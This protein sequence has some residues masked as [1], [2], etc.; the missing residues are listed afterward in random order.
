MRS[1][2]AFAAELGIS[3]TCL[4]KWENMVSFPNTANLLKLSRVF[5]FNNLESFMAYL[6]ETEVTYPEEEQLVAE[7]L[8]K[9]RHLPP[10]RAIQ[11]LETALELLKAAANSKGDA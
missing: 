6:N 4:Q 2:R 5:G 10:A 8:G 9:L 11:L 7:I 1:Q 3:Y